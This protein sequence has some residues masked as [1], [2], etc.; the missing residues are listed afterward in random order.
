[1]YTVFRRL[2][3]VLV[4]KH[5]TKTSFHQFELVTTELQFE[6]VRPILDWFFFPVQSGFAGSYHKRKLVLVL[7]RPKGAEKPD[8]TGLLN[9]NK[10]YDMFNKTTHI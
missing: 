8:L 7:V 1:M 6:P 2:Q 4:P 5:C 10:K 9:T 3:L